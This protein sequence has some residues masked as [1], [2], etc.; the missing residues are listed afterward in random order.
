[1]SDFVTNTCYNDPDMDKN[2]IGRILGHYGM[3]SKK[4]TFYFQPRNNKLTIYWDQ[5]TNSRSKNVSVDRYCSNEYYLK[6]YDAAHCCLFT[7]IPIT[8]YGPQE[9]R[10]YEFSSDELNIMH[11]SVGSAFYVQL[12]SYQNN[13]NFTSGGYISEE[14]A[15]YKSEI[16]I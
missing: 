7:S 11:N 3:C 5:R 10:Y 14:L 1:M 2:A 8:I 6:V 13:G 15:V 9:T 16:Q 4:P 12:I